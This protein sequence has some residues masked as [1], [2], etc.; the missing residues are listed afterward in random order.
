MLAALTVF[1]VLLSLAG[2]GAGFVV[3]AALFA[4]RREKEWTAIF[5][6]STIATSLSG[7]LFPFQ[8]LLPSH[9]IGIL[10]LIVLGLACGALYLY[11]LSGAWRGV[12]V[13]TSLVA[14][15]LNSLVLVVQ[16]FRRVPLL[17]SLAPTLSELPFQAA[18]LG[19][20]LGFLALGWGATKRF[21][22]P[23]ALHPALEKGRSAAQKAG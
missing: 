13:I 2:I 15:Y 1:H 23:F 4:S 22:P 3:V 11:Q 5:L 9:I 10:S 16:L 7:F 12:F 18:Q 19:L 8:Q 14:L 6:V 17:N 21:R 20:L